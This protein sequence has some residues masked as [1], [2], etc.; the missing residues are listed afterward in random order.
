M[1]Q[2]TNYNFR[3][4]MDQSSLLK[5]TITYF[6]LVLS[7]IAESLPQVQLESFLTHFKPFFF[8]FLAWTSCVPSIAQKQTK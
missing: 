6:F 1:N 4:I 3:K 8:F 5:I 2:H 7:F